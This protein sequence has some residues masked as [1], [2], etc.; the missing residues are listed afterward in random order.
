MSASWREAYG[1]VAGIT[2]EE[3]FTMSEI[4]D[5]KSMSSGGKEGGGK[6]GGGKEG[7]ERKTGAER[8]PG[9]GAQPGQRQQS[10]GQPASG[11][12]QGGQSPNRTTQQGGSGSGKPSD[13]DMQSKDPGHKGKS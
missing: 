5:D 12:Q 8:Q 2:Y 7:T 3:V 10:T 11:G 9:A 6:E 13:D 1:G 4:K